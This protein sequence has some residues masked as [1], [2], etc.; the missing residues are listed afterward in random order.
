MLYIIPIISRSAIGKVIPELGAGGSAGDL[1]QPH[2]LELENL[3]D[4][5]IAKLKTL[6]T[7][8]ISDPEVR[9]KTLDI[10]S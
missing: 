3:E 4:E 7:K 8:K 1:I 10:I 2:D 5:D 6:C 9:R